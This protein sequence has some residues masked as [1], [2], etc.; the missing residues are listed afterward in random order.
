MVCRG[1]LLSRSSGVL[2]D[3]PALL[4]STVD[5]IVLFGTLLSISLYGMWRSRQN[6]SLDNYLKGDDSIKWGT[7]GLSVMATQASAITFLSTPGLAY[8]EGLLFV[9]NYFGMPFAIIFICVFFIPIYRKLKVYTAYEYLGKRFDAKSQ[10]LG[11]SLFLIQRGLAAGITIYAPAIVVSTLLGWNLDLTIVLVGVL[12]I[13]YTVSGGTKAVSITQRYQMGVIMLGMFIAFGMIFREL[14][15]GVSF[16]DAVSVAGVLGKMNP[17]DLEFNLNEKYNI[18]SGLLGGF[19]L[20]LSY[21]GTDQS[22]VQRYLAGS[23]TSGSRFGLL[24]NAVVKIPMQFFILFVGVMVFVFYQFERPPVFFDQAT[25]DKLR[26]SEYVETFEALEL[27][28][29]SL[30]DDRSEAVGELAQALGGGDQVAIDQAS[31]EAIRLDNRASEIRSEVKGLIESSNIGVKAKDSDYVFITF[32]VN[33]LP[34][35]LVGL[36]IAVIFSAAMSSTASELNALG[37]TTMVDFYRRIRTREA[38]EAHYVGVSRILTVVWG[39]VAMI[40]ALYASLVS[41]LIE[42]VNKIGSLF[43]GPILG[44]FLVAFLFKRIGGHSVFWAAL[45]AQ[46]IVFLLNGFSSIG[47]LWFNPIGCLL[48]IGFAHVLHW[49]IFSGEASAKEGAR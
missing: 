35:G 36:M 12:V 11:A 37:S 8:D 5:Y 43:Y 16:G 44:I 28:Y 38:S 17:V 42:T 25:I 32:I 23:S 47:Y 2:L 41:N 33:Y 48:V 29:G 18:W 22:Q 27:E 45:L 4:V 21:F 6:A 20:S 49:T 40:F 10:Y 19:F 3:F 9:Q 39:I 14:P 13:V 30:V 34:T 1:V 26:N 46:A 15:E 24:L 31:L 7:I